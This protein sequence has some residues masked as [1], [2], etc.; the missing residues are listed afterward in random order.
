MNTLTGG[1]LIA[2]GDFLFL[3]L[4]FVDLLGLQEPLFHV[5]SCLSQ[6]LQSGLC[7]GGLDLQ[8]SDLLQQQVCLLEGLG[9]GIGRP[10]LWILGKMGLS[11]GGN[12][13]LWTSLC[14][15]FSFVSSMLWESVTNRDKVLHGSIGI[16]VEIGI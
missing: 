1:Q 14:F 4:T 12:S 6:S 8:L 15:H 3:S 13:V 7:L 9:L 5:Y 16:I 2:W 11:N 10:K